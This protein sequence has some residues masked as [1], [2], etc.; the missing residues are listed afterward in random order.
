L[1]QKIIKNY[2]SKKKILLKLLDNLTNKIYDSRE[3][4]LKIRK[5]S[6]SMIDF[7][8]F[9]FF[10]EQNI[11]FCYTDQIILVVEKS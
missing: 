10:V 5:A 9:Q 2:P 4:Y 3:P 7:E 1:C 11:I 8:V 6:L